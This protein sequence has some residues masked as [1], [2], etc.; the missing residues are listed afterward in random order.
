MKLNNKELEE[1]L[2]I[3]EQCKVLIPKLKYNEELSKTLFYCMKD[4]KQPDRE[5]IQRVHN[6]YLALTMIGLNECDSSAFR[7]IDNYMENEY[8]KY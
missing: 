3:T 2:T 5:T 8:W 6:N 1:L 4:K 7:K